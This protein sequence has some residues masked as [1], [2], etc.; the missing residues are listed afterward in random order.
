MNK[1]WRR[2]ADRID[3]M[4]L[5][6]RTLIFLTAALLC[7]TTLNALLI[8]PKLAAEKRLSAGIAQH[9]AEMRKLDT[10]LRKIALSRDADPDRE[11]R[12]RLEAL[13]AQLSELDAKVADHQRRFT[14]PAQ[15]REMVAGLLSRNSRLRL[16]DMKTLP[17]TTIAGDAP[18]KIPAQ[19]RPAPRAAAERLI[20]RHGVE[21]TVG[22]TYLEA[23]RYLAE[24]EKLPTH[25]Y[26]GRLEMKVGQHPDLQIKV[27]LYTLSLDRA[28]MVL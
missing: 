1:R 13:N 19:A 27:T 23:M 3:G 17:T 24:L 12:A 8:E 10:E 15:V 11:N 9:Q 20:Y 14:D 2:I 16:V 6:E 25:L 7:V 5:R 4:S 22:G 28:W 26:W 21:I 18:A